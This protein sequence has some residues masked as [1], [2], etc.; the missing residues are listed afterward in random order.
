MNLREHSRTL[1]RQVNACFAESRIARDALAQC[2]PGS[3]A[4]HETIVEAIL[5]LECKQHLG[6]WHA[7]QICRLLDAP[8]LDLPQ[9]SGELLLARKEQLTGALRKVE[10]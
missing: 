6:C 2:L 10:Q 7:R 4:R 8:L 9:R 5:A 3:V 1:L